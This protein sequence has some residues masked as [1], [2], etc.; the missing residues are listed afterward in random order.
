MAMAMRRLE[1]TSRVSESPRAKMSQPFWNSGS[2]ARRSRCRCAAPGGSSYFQPTAAAA[3]SAFG[4]AWRC[5]RCVRARWFF[6]LQSCSAYFT[7]SISKMNITTRPMAVATARRMVWVRREGCGG[8]E[9]L[10]RGR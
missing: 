8:D 7:A 2:V 6:R 3:V 10:R 5:E 4:G 9:G 1:I